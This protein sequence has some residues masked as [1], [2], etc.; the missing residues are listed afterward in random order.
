VCA[1]QI[2]M[3]D[4]P[5]PV[6]PADPTSSVNN[7][8][9]M[10]GLSPTRPASLNAIPDVDV[11]APSRPSFVRAEKCTVPV[12]PNHR[13]TCAGIS[14]AA[15]D[16]QKSFSEWE[17]FQYIQI[18]RASGV[19]RSSSLNP[20]RFR[21]RER[22]LSDE[23]RVL[24]VLHDE[25]RDGG[26]VLDAAQRRHRTTQSRRSVHDRSVEFDLPEFVRQTAVSDACAS[27][28]SFSTTSAPSTAASTGSA[29]ATSA[30]Y[31]FGSACG[32]ALWDATITGSVP[33]TTISGALDACGAPSNHD[34]AASP[35][36]AARRRTT[37]E[38]SLHGV[39]L[40]VPERTIG[41]N[42]MGRLPFLVAILAV[43][44][45][46]QSGRDDFERFLSAPESEA[47]QRVEA[48]LRVPD[49]DLRRWALDRPTPKRGPRCSSRTRE[50]AR[51]P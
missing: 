45:A 22:P 19:R 9:P 16:S 33:R 35:A 51:T 13:F 39:F 32:N 29:P 40:G 50:T 12:I 25:A 21:E 11:Q 49:A 8:A 14:S 7:P 31:A 23:H 42:P 27:L 20:V 18:S 3:F 24:R 15:G 30:A 2:A 46:A 34:V 28:G 1:P 4:S 6:D 43:V 41:A 26:R 38:G 47:A 17:R 36:P 37:I 44:A 10:I 48:L 5:R